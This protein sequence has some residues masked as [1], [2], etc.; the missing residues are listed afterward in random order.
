MSCAY[1]GRM[2]SLPARMARPRQLPPPSR[3]A[4]LPVRLPTAAVC[5]DTLPRAHTHTQ[6]FDKLLVFND[7]DSSLPLFGVLSGGQLSK[8][9]QGAPSSIQAF[10]EPAVL[11]GGSYSL[12]TRKESTLI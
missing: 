9:C 6:S 8:V 12:P 4:P 7:L 1:A 5:R 3:H 2:S 10:G 11:G